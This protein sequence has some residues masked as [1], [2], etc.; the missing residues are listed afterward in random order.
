VLVCV[1][2][3][4]SSAATVTS[5]DGW[6]QI[7][8]TDNSFKGIVE[9][10]KCD[11]TEG[12][13]F[14]WTIGQ[15][16]GWAMGISRFSGV[17]ATTQSDVGRSVNTGSD[18]SAECT[19]ITTATD[20]AMVLAMV[21]ANRSTLSFTAPDGMTEAWEI[22]GNRSATLDYVVQATAGATGDKTV[23]MSN[24]QTWIGSL[25]ALRP[26]VTASAVPV[27]INS[28]RQRRN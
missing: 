27:I 6:N 12:D 2:S 24:S 10:R 11:G 19:G 7:T 1:L 4:Q 5:P 20:G 26:T 23:A 15:S 16:T 17:D 25:W 21:N 3:I 22:G 13:T 18:D 28:Y 8:K 14:A 9:W